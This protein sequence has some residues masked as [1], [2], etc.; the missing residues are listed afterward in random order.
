MISYVLPTR[1]RPAVLARTLAKLGELSAH[2]AEVIVVDNAS[3]EP[4]R[5]EPTLANGIQARVIRLDRNAGAAGRNAGATATNP[6]SRWIVMLD[7][8][9]YPLDVGHLEALR[10]ARPDVA[11]VGAEIWLPTVD[12]LPSHEAGGLPEVIVG[13]GAAIRRNV[14]LEVG[15]Y[16]EK[17]DYYAEEYDL[18]ARL[19]LRGWLVGFDKRFGVMHHKERQGRNFARIVRNLTRNNAW[20]MQRYAPEAD[21]AALVRGEVAR[22][23][24]I[25]AKE[26]AST[27]WVRGIADL[28]M[29]LWRQPRMEMNTA[30]WARFTG[31]AAARQAVNAA[32]EQWG[33]H[34]VAIVAP[35]KNEHVV[36]RAVI[37]AGLE[38]VDDVEDADALMVGTLSPGPM[39][40]ATAALRASGKPVI[41]PLAS[42]DRPVADAAA[43]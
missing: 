30:Q 4:V 23:R 13:C 42:A 8:D 36:R 10:H 2:E 21:R 12:G 38:I 32:T 43:A 27:G 16:D 28:A 22:Y 14:F 41:V 24:R 39:I 35:G 33:L 34:R 17:F 3:A 29:T 6:A 31:L 7:D 11:A 26:N 40:D 18:C 5:L 25:A 37:D 9:S 20:V 1:D 19:I 15:G